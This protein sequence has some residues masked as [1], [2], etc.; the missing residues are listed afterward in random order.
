MATRSTIAIEYL[1]GTVKQVYCHFDGYLEHNGKILQENYTNPTKLN[2]IME[3]GD[4]SV[5]S[6]NIGT[7]HDFDDNTYDQCKFYSRDR[8]EIG[9]EAKSFIDFNDYLQNMQSEDFNYILRFI[10]GNSVWFV[11]HYDSNGKFEPLSFA[12]TRQSV[13]SLK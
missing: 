6:K 5:L 11:S 12:L 7:Q 9:T 4:L 10:N 1:D 3:L 2:C 13:E 8:N